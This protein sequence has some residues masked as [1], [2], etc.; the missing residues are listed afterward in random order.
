MQDIEATVKKYPECQKNQPSPL[1]APLIPW[2]WPTRPWSR[3][4]DF[5]GPFLNHMYLILVDSHSKWIEAHV[6]SSIAAS[7]TVQCL[8]EIFAQ[9]GLPERIV[10]DNGPTFTSQEFQKFL[11]KN[12]IQHTTPPP[13]HPASNGLAEC[14]V[15]T[16]KAGVKKF[17]HTRIVRFLQNLS[18][19]YHRSFTRRTVDGSSLALRSGSIETGSGK[20]SYT[21]TSQT[22]T[23]T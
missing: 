15:K 4:I 16:F 6:M 10:S 5:A 3:H 13:Y 7:A 21:S 14:T 1:L 8:C 11:H 18:P 19:V 20:T 22:E 9:F 23:I 17:I 12:G 2:H